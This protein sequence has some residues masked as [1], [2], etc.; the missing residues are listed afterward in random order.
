MLLVLSLVSFQSA[1]PSLSISARSP[2][3]SLVPLGRVTRLGSNLLAAAQGFLAAQGFA[4]AEQGFF[5]FGEHGFCANAVP[6]MPNTNTPIMAACSGLW[7]SF[8]VCSSEF[9]DSVTGCQK[10]SSRD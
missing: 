2:V 5:P 8:I 10:S 6:P 7:C 4:L 3:A 1:S 9:Y